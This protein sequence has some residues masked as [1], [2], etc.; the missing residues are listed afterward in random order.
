[1]RAHF[2]KDE[3]SFGAVPLLFLLGML[4]RWFFFSAR[5]IGEVVIVGPL[6]RAFFFQEP[7]LGLPCLS[8]VAQW[9]EI[10]LKGARGL[11][12]GLFAFSWPVKVTWFS[13]KSIGLI[14]LSP[15]GDGSP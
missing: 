2:G 13:T 12:D 4:L 9:F 14:W 3:Q 11:L 10:S 8:G 15:A 7:V 6:D 1:M 5:V